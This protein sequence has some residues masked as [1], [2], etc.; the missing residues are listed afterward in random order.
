MIRRLFFGSLVVLAFLLSACGAANNNEN[1]ATRESVVVTLAPD[2]AGIT[3]QAISISGGQREP[4]VATEV[5]LAYI[6]W[7]EDKSDGAFYQDDATSPITIT[8]EAGFFTFS[9]IEVRDYV[10]VIG[11]L[12]GVNVPLANP[13]GS[14]QIFTP[15]VGQILDVGVL[16]VDIVNAG[17]V[18]GSLPTTIAPSYPGNNQAVPSPAYP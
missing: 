5:R 6:A 4:L 1:N 14:A 12:F 2:L 17:A 7:N 3:G 11:D 16:E 10:I 8:N 9:N 15:T 18:P 13:D